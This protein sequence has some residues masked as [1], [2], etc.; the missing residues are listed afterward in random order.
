MG[1]AKFEEAVALIGQHPE[2][3]HHRLPCHV[4][5]I[6]AA[7]K[8]LGFKIPP[9]HRRFL[10]EFGHLKFGGTELHGTASDPLHN[11]IEQTSEQ[12]GYG[13]PMHFVVVASLGDGEYAAIDTRSWQRQFFS[14]RDK[15]QVFLWEPENPN[16]GEQLGRLAPNFGWFFYHQVI[17]ALEL[18]R[19]ATVDT[20]KFRF[21]AS[22]EVFRL[23]SPGLEKCRRSVEPYLRAEFAG[24]SL[25]TLFGDLRYIPIVMPAGMRERYP[26]RSKL[27]RDQEI[28]DCSPQLN[29]D[30]FVSGSFEDQLKEYIRGIALS[31]PHLKGLG[32]TPEQIEDF[33][34][35]MDERR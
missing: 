5:T 10:T 35:I 1:T 24:S 9:L 13:L 17:G 2:L 33:K 21:W 27:K 20:C 34:R 4:E 3:L 18:H 15:C 32:A 31:A 23:A 16:S 26:E 22:A 11:I 8:E 19:R 12:R 25:T 28:Y 30:V 7:E 29:Y 14:R 6:L